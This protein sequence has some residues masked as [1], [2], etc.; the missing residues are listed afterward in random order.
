MIQTMDI[1]SNWLI[2]SKMQCAKLEKLAIRLGSARLVLE[3]SNAELKTLGIPPELISRLRQ[4]ATLIDP[5]LEWLEQNS[6]HHIICW[7]DPC[8][9]SQLREIPGPPI[10]LYI[11]GEIAILNEAQLAVVGS[12]NPSPMGLEL[13]KEFSAG[14]SSR[15]FIITSGLA[16]GIDAASHS[17]ALE[18][19]GL[20]IAVLG[21]GLLQIYPRLHS[22]L[23]DKIAENGALISEHAPKESPLAHHFPKRNRIISGLSH[24]V[25]V[26]EA[27]LKSGSLITA[28]LAN[29]QGREVFAIPGSPHHK[30]AIGCNHLI[31]QGAKLVC[32]IEDL[33]EE[34]QPSLGS[35]KTLPAGLPNQFNELDLDSRQYKLLECT[36][37]ELSSIDQI[38]ARSG[39]S[40]ELARS[41]LLELELKGFIKTG[42]GGYTRN[43]ALSRANKPK[44][45][46]KESASC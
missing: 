23:A 27:S 15:G 22:R 5:D 33:L 37:F 28:R 45:T 46:D 16:L 35:S 13:A 38:I 18:V 24:G 2:I 32:S 29:E 12:R 7:E 44:Q 20:S 4:P 40:P 36:G 31:Q 10:I 9:P 3:M 25:L 43:F 1:L 42:T 17:A 39:F 11:K 19:N 21:S 34:L 41:L 26:I 6:R 14:L 30:L 8:Y